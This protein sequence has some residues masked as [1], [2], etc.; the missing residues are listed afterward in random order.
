MEPEIIMRQLNLVESPGNM[1]ADTGGRAAKGI[2]LWPLACWDYR[3]E[4]R[5]GQGCVSYEYRV[6]PGTDL[7]VGPIPRP[8]KSY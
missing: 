8:E 7:C 1:M 5:R 6:L 2:G 4:S 3:F